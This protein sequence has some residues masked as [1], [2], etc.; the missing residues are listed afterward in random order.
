MTVI[1][2]LWKRLFGRRRNWE[3]IECDS[4]GLWKG[5]FYDAEFDIWFKCPTCNG[6]GKVK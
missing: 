1:Q 3:C 6:N 4:W 2:R 5:L